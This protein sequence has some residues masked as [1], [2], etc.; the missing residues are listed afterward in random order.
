V[1]KAHPQGTKRML[2]DGQFFTDSRSARMIPVSPRAPATKTSNDFPLALNTG[3]VRDHWHTMTRTAK[4]SNLSAHTIEPYAELHTDDALTLGINNNDLVRLESPR[5]EIIVR[6]RVNS[7]Y[8]RGG[9]FVPMHW[10]NE[11]SFKGCVNALIAPNVDPLSGQPESK[12]TPVRVSL[13]ETSWQGFTLTRT[14]PALNETDYWTKVRG[15]E[16][17]QYEIA[18]QE[19]PKDWTETT[20]A[21]FKLTDVPVDWIEYQDPKAGDYRCATLND[22]RLE[23]C[24]YISS[25]GKLPS[26]QWL[27]D[28]FDHDKLEVFDRAN[29]L[30]G[31]PYDH[32]TDRGKTVC[33]C[34]G[35]GLNTIL[36]AIEKDGLDSIKAI[37]K[38]LKAGTN[39]GS[40]I[41]EIRALLKA[42]DDDIAA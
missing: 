7:D 15:K 13:Y 29:L 14:P 30:S 17:W 25:E 19:T 2:S 40:C 1:T 31:R 4:S 6:A 39:C 24:E 23:S 12:Y 41:P 34:F 26:R 8:R 36:Q 33:A 9:V 32:D 5:G 11:Y 42:R 16:Y 27:G 21:M 35:I 18:G 22:D 28:L 10:N 37:G 20:R 3:R 38:K